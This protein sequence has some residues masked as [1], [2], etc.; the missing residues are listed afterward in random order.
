MT[1]QFLAWALSGQEGSVP[2][3]AGTLTGLAFPL[4][5]ESRD[6]RSATTEELV[7]AS[8]VQILGTRAD[9]G[10]AHGELPWRPD[11]G[12]L[13]HR[14]QY[15]PVDDAFAALVETRVIGALSQWEPRI[16]VTKTVVERVDTEGGVRA[17]VQ[18]HY[19]IVQPT[20]G[21][22]LSGAQRVD[23]PLLS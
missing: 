19:V 10:R 6:L 11:F 2:A 7:R 1:D 15:M 16:R 21:T 23:V 9:D 20:T 14:L 13:L 3:S 22:P 4:Q 17:V 18:V 12:S 5:R 8:I